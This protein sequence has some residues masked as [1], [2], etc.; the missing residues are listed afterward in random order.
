M[1]GQTV[2]GRYR[3]GIKQMHEGMNFFKRYIPGF[4]NCQLM[5]AAPQV[6]IRDGRR[7]LGL[8]T[9]TQEDILRLR[10]FED[11]IAQG[12][13]MIDIHRPDSDGTIKFKI[14]RGRHYDIPLRS[15]IAAQRNNL[16]LAG[17]CIS[18]DFGAIAALRVQVICMA[19][20]HAAGVAAGLLSQT[21][22]DARKMPY[23]EVRT[24]LLSQG[25]IL[26]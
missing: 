22:E 23:K 19:T 4:E 6:G 1:E 5:I 15:L 26:D 13:Y 7:I 11:V 3:E 14:P 12:C 2:A 10:Q 9:V 25:A 24:Q 21:G 20:G 18:A 16:F 17:K 8:Y